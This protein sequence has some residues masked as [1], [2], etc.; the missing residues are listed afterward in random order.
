ML[1]FHHVLLLVAEESAVKDEDQDLD[2]QYSH[3][4]ANDEHVDVSQFLLLEFRFVSIK[5]LNCIVKL[6]EE[7]FNVES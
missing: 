3:R 2:L 5:P 1:Y 6:L 7:L 4:R